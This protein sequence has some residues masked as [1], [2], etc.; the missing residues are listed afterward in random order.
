MD[1]SLLLY[2]VTKREQEPSLLSKL[3]GRHKEKQQDQEARGEDRGS[4][5]TW[6]IPAMPEIFKSG[7]CE[8]S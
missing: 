5:S 4:N 7:L 1:F 8:I 6:I 3:N 2:Y